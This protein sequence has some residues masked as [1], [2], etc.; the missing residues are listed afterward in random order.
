MY[1]FCKYL[2][3]DFDQNVDMWELNRETPQ[4]PPPAAR[5]PVGGVQQQQQQQRRRGGN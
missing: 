5:P 3:G 4:V 1:Y 2:L